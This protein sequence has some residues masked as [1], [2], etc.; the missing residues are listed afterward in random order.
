MEIL[1]SAHLRLFEHFPF[2]PC[3]ASDG[4]CDRPLVGDVQ[5]TG[6]RAHKF[7]I[8]TLGSL[9]SHSNPN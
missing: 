7:I 8:N 4:G 1:L 6:D 2:E 5:N 9:G 3:P